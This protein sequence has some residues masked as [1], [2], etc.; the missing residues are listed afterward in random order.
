[1]PV[2]R[3]ITVS[4]TSPAGG[5]FHVPLTFP[6]C[7]VHNSCSTSRSRKHHLGSRSAL[8]SMQ[9]VYKG[10]RTKHL[11]GQHESICYSSH[12]T[13]RSTAAS[14][15]ARPHTKTELHGSRKVG[16][17]ASGDVRGPLRRTSATAPSRSDRA[18]FHEHI[19]PFA[20]SART[21]TT[22]AVAQSRSGRVAHPPLRF[23]AVAV[24]AL[25]LALD[26]KVGHGCQT[27]STSSP[28]PGQNR[29]G[30][31]HLLHGLG[32]LAYKRTETIETLS[33]LFSLFSLCIPMV[34]DG[35]RDVTA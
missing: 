21:P 16:R 14:L 31:A 26:R 27:V 30:L 2:C 29:L 19:G 20:R 18:S 7:A 34:G 28:K 11:G 25:D 32:T 13:S 23:V 35:D 22:A 4:S 10:S 3:G 12:P 9:Y 6:P 8:G 15:S 5:P 1:M 33:A 24:L 17:A